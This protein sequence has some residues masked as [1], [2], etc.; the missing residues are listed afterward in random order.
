MG[1]LKV[2]E[3]PPQSCLQAGCEAGLEAGRVDGTMCKIHYKTKGKLIAMP[4]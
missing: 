3:Q 4:S 1:L 2:G